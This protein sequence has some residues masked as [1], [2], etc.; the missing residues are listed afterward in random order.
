MHAED[1]TLGVVFEA[2]AHLQVPLFQ[3]PYVW[4]QEENWEP[5]WES[6]SE[7]VLRRHLGERRRP[8]FLGS[9]VL[10]QSDTPT[11][12]VVVRQIIDGQQRLSTLQILIAAMR[13]LARE[14]QQSEYSEAFDRLVRNFVPS[15][16]RPE[17]RY[18]V[19]PTNQD[20]GAFVQA[21]DSG[22]LRAIAEGLGKRE[23]VKHFGHRML[24][25][26][27]FFYRELEEL[28]KD[29]SESDTADVFSA[30]YAA[31]RED[32]VLVVVDLDKTDDPQLIFETLNALG[33][34]LLPSDLVKNLLFRVAASEEADI[35]HLYEK[36]WKP[37][38]TNSEYW[39]A[40][41]TQGRLKWGR[42]DIFVA[43]YLALKRR[44]IITVPHLFSEFRSYLVEGDQSAEQSLLSLRDYATTFR[45][46]DE[47]P[48]TSREGVFFSRLEALDTNM[49]IPVL[50]EVLKS[51]S[52]DG[53]H[54][55]FIEILESYLVRRAICLLTYKNYNRVFAELLRHLSR[56]EFRSER[57]QEFLLS[58]EGETS[59]WPSDE[60]FR[61]AVE[62][63]PAYDKLKRSRVLMLLEAIERSLYEDKSERI[64][65]LDDLTVEHIMPQRWEENWPLR[66]AS[67]EERER[68]EALL[69]S[70]GNLTLVTGKLNPSLSNAGW[71][72][73]R[74][75]L[76]QH[77]ALALNR[78]LLGNEVWN[79]NTIRDR[80]RWIAEIAL[81]IWP[82]E[83][84]S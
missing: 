8:H 53:D 54:I 4:K 68:R 66:D 21:L 3:R 44:D 20:R 59:I 34:P 24:D 7:A 43:H 2:T 50:L 47:Y 63:M 31:L 71:D 74:H 76:Q 40:E 55:R 42:I 73:K 29:E 39:R 52:E 16:K 1:R 69:H 41:V 58:R 18:K 79:E 84:V 36:A 65:I 11:G 64:E 77:S 35:E 62:T 48:R 61:T 5:L 83:S 81:R 26:Y 56:T 46:F 33:T 12:E 9:I 80:G 19:W 32:V 57:L 82:R 49:A 23:S 28:L 25:C 45:S 22:S 27:A 38:D 37:F 13:D 75:A 60:Q 10:D 72:K 30:M 17:S 70:F 67:L 78:E 14:Y 51:P 15:S 6:F